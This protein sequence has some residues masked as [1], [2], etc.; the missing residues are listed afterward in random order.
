M[1][2][3]QEDNRAFLLENWASLIAVSGSAPSLKYNSIQ[4]Y[5]EKFP[6]FSHWYHML[7]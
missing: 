4:D 6:T 3:T 2:N 1:C 7:F 5:L